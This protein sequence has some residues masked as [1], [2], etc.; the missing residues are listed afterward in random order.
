MPPGAGAGGEARGAGGELPLTERA[1]TSAVSCG[2]VPFAE[3]LR[4]LEPFVGLPFCEE[5]G[6]V[7]AVSVFV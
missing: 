3:S 4:S 6:L 1:G 2:T 7:F 5:G